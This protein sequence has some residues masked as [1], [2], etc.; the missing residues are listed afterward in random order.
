VTSLAARVEETNEDGGLPT[1]TALHTF[2]AFVVN[3]YSSMSTGDLKVVSNDR[4][5]FKLFTLKISTLPYHSDLN[6]NRLMRPLVVY[7]ETIC[8]RYL[9]MF[10]DLKLLNL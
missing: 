4:L 7:F 10:I 6:R 2:E 1:I 8:F 5:L 3:Q 9:Q